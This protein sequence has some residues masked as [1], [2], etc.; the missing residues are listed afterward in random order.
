[1][2]SEDY[3]V[4]IQS[5]EP[6]NIEYGDIWIDPTISFFNMKIN[7]WVQLLADVAI[8]DVVYSTGEFVKALISQATPPTSDVGQIWHNSVTDEY[9][10]CLNTWQPYA[11][12]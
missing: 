3:K 2:S 1:M 6:E 5:A 9:Y 8:V 11:G 10:I 4:Y 12:V 7:G